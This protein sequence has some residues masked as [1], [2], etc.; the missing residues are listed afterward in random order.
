[1]PCR[2]PWV[3]VPS[4]AS[5][6]IE[7]PC[8]PG[9]FWGLNGRLIACCF[10]RILPDVAR[11]TFCFHTA[12]ST[13]TTRAAR[14]SGSAPS[15][16]PRRPGAGHARAAAWPP[17]PPAS[18]RRR[19]DPR[20]GADRG[21][22]AAAAASS[23]RQRGR[24][25]SGRRSRR[26]ALAGCTAGS[27]GQGSCESRPS[28]TP[29]WSGRSRAACHRAARSPR[30]WATPSPEPC[31]SRRTTSC[32]CSAVRTRFAHPTPSSGYDP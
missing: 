11:P 9:V 10:S 27:C 29:S 2:R 21:R 5:F 28:S 31:Y 17:P 7:H 13:P 6:G 19:D 4:S 23:A 14:V 26:T 1:M 30:L 32:A 8:K 12:T 24:A 3:R 16:G 15:H 20:P 22:P 18:T 25:L